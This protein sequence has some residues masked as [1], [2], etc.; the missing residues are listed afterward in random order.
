MSISVVV[1]VDGF[2]IKLNLCHVE[3][4]YVINL[5]LASRV[6]AMLH[7]VGRSFKRYSRFMHIRLLS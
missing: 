6:K 3:E 7:T 2:A 1:V 4:M 5:T